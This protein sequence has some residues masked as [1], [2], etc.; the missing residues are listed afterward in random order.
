[1]FSLSPLGRGSFAFNQTWRSWK[2]FGT[3]QDS[4]WQRLT[5]R[6][7]GNPKTTEAS[8]SIPTSQ[9]IPPPLAPTRHA[10]Q[11][12]DRLRRAR[13]EL[14]LS[15][16]R[17]LPTRHAPQP[18]DRFR[19]ARRKMPLP[20]TRQHLPRLGPLDVKFLRLGSKVRFTECPLPCCTCIALYYSICTM[21]RDLV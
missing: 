12:A 20:Q 8:I 10:L 13:P 17:H 21:F 7:E 18:S 2:R 4:L 3:G 19:S 6:S 15:P 14:S 1:M 16:G 5:L 11:L 9:A